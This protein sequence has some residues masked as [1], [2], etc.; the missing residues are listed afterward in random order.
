MEDKQ[1]IFFADS[2]TDNGTINHLQMPWDINSE[3]MENGF[4]STEEFEN[5]KKSIVAD[6]GFDPIEACGYH[7]AVL[8]Y[9]R[10]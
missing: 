9:Q 5:V 2:F 6:L 10:S 1:T 3:A 8:I 7:I 4:L